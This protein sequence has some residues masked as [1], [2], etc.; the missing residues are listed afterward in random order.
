MYLTVRL[1]IAFKNSIYAYKPCVLTCWR[2]FLIFSILVE[3]YL[4]VKVS[5]PHI[6]HE[7]NDFLLDMECRAEY[8]PILPGY[9][10]F[11]DFVACTVNLYLFANRLYK[12][13]K[14]TRKRLEKRQF[15]H[16]RSQDQTGT[17][18]NSGEHTNNNSKNTNNTNNTNDATITKI[19]TSD[20]A[21]STAVTK[22][23]VKDIKNTG[24]NDEYQTLPAMSPVPDEANDISNNNNN[25]NETGSPDSAFDVTN[26]ETGIDKVD[27]AMA[28]GNNNAMVR[29]NSRSHNNSIATN[30]NENTIEIEEIVIIDGEENSNDGA[31]LS[32]S[33]KKRPITK[34]V[35]M[36]SSPKCKHSKA[37]RNDCELLKIIRKQTILTAIGVISTII[38]MIFV[39]VF[40]MGLVWYV[41]MLIWFCLDFESFACFMCIIYVKYAL[42]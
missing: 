30:N 15:S 32:D 6:V 11:T 21:S 13:S 24:N 8:D 35:S 25:N 38:S 4:S 28:N 22:T 39:A 29:V 10:G 20:A 12:I 18:S 19:D 1:D 36:E 31:Q 41:F 3:C 9:I 17:L 37:A 40:S 2:L 5:Y 14:A 26:I 7:N 42:L 27:F 33:E 16:D 23:T 34:S